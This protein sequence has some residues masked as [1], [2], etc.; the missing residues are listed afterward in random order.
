MNKILT[1]KD[2]SNNMKPPT[3]DEI[4]KEV[5]S[6]T[7]NEVNDDIEWFIK[8]MIYMRDKWE[9]SLKDE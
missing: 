8:G 3:D 5:Y 1:N 4:R 9:K 7:F 6:E 2:K